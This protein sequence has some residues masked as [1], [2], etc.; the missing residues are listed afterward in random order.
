LDK[1]T[2][3][4]EDDLI[5]YKT[6]DSTTTYDFENPDTVVPKTSKTK[7]K[8]TI[9]NYVDKD[10]LSEYGA[11]TFENQFVNEISPNISKVLN[12]VNNKYS[13]YTKFPVINKILEFRKIQNMLGDGLCGYYAILSQLYEVYSGDTL[14][15]FNN[16]EEI[17]IVAKM[18]V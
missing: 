13:D 16:N 2:N 9:T 8:T 5:K 10:N 1:K 3:K 4:L 12:N 14:G 7:T 18:M 15:P 11:P 6:N 17:M